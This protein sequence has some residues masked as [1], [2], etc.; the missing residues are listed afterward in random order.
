V[1]PAD[2]AA[3][4]A[5]ARDALLAALVADVNGRWTVEW[6]FEG[7]RLLPLALRLARQL[8]AAG[9]EPRL[10]FADAGA[11]ALAKRDGP[12][13]AERC[14]DFNSLLREQGQETSQGLLLAVAPSPAEYGDFERLCQQH[15]GAVVTLNGRLEDAAVGIGSVARQRRRGFVA[16]WQAAYCL[17]PLAEGV[18]RRSYPDQWQLY[19]EDVDGFRLANQFERRPDGEQIAEALAGEAGLGLAGNL[20]AINELIDGLGR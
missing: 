2:L 20:R 10:V 13:L 18:L 5:Q 3:A 14:A 16:E 7:L 4:E 9:R 1:L 17:Q 8:V 12:D 15:R 6:R 11:A 19:R